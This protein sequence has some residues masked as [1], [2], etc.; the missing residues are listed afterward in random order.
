[1][2][3]ID[4]NFRISNFDFSKTE[5]KRELQFIEISQLIICQQC[6]IQYCH[7]RSQVLHVWLAGGKREE[8]SKMRSGK[9]KQ[10]K[11]KIKIKN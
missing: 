4:L 6:S 5:G 8:G 9:V 2:Q 3:C 1:M 7:N 10:N 11:I